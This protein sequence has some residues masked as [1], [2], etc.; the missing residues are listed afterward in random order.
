MI[1]A[2]QPGDVI[3]IVCGTDINYIPHLGVLLRSIAVTNR[4][5]PIRAHVLHDGIPESVKL[6]VAQC[7]PTITV[8]WYEVA[9]HQVLEFRP[10]LQITRA[11]YLRLTM[12]KVLPSSMRRVLFLDVDMTVT[13]SLLPLW[14]TDLQG[15]V[16]AAVQD[17][18]GHA[19]EFARKYSLSP[20]GQYFNAGVLLFDFE[21]LCA[22]LYLENSITLLAQPGAHYEYAD[23]DALNIVLWDRWLPIN[24]KWNFQ[25]KFYYDDFAAF[26]PSGWFEPVII[27]YTETFKPWRRDEWHPYAWIYLKNLLRT[28]YRHDVTLKGGIGWLTRYKWWLR[29]LLKR[30]RF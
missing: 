8:E 6:T 29:Y 16:C 14:Q 21:K 19:E 7:A 25:R 20:P 26:R 18:G 22:G 12:T 2:T 23:Q 28:P 9:D 15:K 27:H 13:G 3:E 10:L 1:V 5:Q 4:D 30:G 17:P 11:T 24:L